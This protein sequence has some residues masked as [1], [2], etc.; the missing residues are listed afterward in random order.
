MFLNLEFVSNFEFN[1]SCPENE[2]RNLEAI[3]NSSK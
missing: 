1:I 2:M 3:I